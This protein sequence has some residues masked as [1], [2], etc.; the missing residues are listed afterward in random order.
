MLLCCAFFLVFGIAQAKSEPQ[1]AASSTPS[2]PAPWQDAVKLLT[3]KIAAVADQSK[4]ASLEVTNISSLSAA[5]A[6]EIGA[7]LQAGLSA[8]LHLV[9]ATEAETRI[10]VTLSEGEAGYIW[11]AQVSNGGGQSVEMVAFPS[12]GNPA[13]RAVRPGLSLERKI[14]WS[15]H[16]PFLD[17]AI[18]EAPANNAQQIIVLETR[19]IISYEQR[20]SKWIP[21]ATITLNPATALPRDVRGTIWQG[22]QEFEALLPGEACSGTPGNLLSLSC[23]PN[24]STNPEMSWPL[25]STAGRANAMFRANRNFFDGLSGAG[26]GEAKL[27]AFYSAAGM[28]ENDGM[29]WMFAGTD[30]KARLYE[31]TGTASATFSG[32]GDDIATLETACSHEW[33]VL[34]TGA[35]DWTQPDHIQ[36]YEIRDQQAVAKGQPLDFPGPILA[37]WPSTD[38]KSAR[39]VSRNLQTGMY[40]AS[41]ITVSC[42][43]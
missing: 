13:V 27:P 17:F 6:A 4:R 1:G 22:S 18:P 29:S 33:D 43:E 7:A 9:S 11:V 36:L 39:V 26:Q 2:L 30:G 12:E 8:R 3:D 25:A 41:I 40:E 32:W 19:R 20:E 37:L 24:A 28:S 10:I 16:E 21:G 35:G 34:V 42:S 15:Q 31:G 38:S 23:A 5:G 14:V